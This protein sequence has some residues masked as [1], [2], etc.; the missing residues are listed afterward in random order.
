MLITAW[1][2][3]TGLFEV[4]DKIPD[5]P[6]NK[7]QPNPADRCHEDGSYEVFPCLPVSMTIRNHLMKVVGKL[8]DLGGTLSNKTSEK[9]IGS[10]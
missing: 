7:P 9:G 1:S 8:D 4:F 2:S 3:R 10:G 6:G 5:P